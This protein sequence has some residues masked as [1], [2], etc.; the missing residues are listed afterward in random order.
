[1]SELKTICIMPQ[2]SGVGGPAAF[3]ERISA[4]L[5]KHGIEVS[6]DLHA[7][8]DAVLLISAWRQIG[9]LQRLKRSGV[10]VIQR[11]DGINW[12]H[13][14]IPFN[15]RYYLKAEYGNLLMRYTR[16]ALADRI[17]YQSEF[18]AQRWQQVY[19]AVRA[20]HTVIHNGIDLQAVSPQ[21]RVNNA[22]ERQRILVVEG[23]FGGG[24]D[25]GVKFVLDMAAGVE[26]RYGIPVEV[27]L[28]GRVTAA[29]Q[30]KW[31]DYTQVPVSWMGIVPREEIPV[32][33]RSAS[34][35]FSVDLNPAC[36]NTV[37]EA[38]AC[39]L[40]VV[41]YD[42]GALPEMVSG[43]A[44]RVVPYQADPWKLELPPT[45]GLID[46]A[47]EILQNQ[48]RFRAGARARAE[49]SFDLKDMVRKYLEVLQAV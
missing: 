45:E 8:C 41:A 23:S 49:E 43:D 30:D 24:Y 11:L 27:Q 46:A 32:L 39:G 18:V 19:G 37:I 6:A 42:T 20:P 16:R 21:G 29:V 44:G 9:Q 35:F 33:N 22:G 14:V 1:M 15:L 17:I 48:V 12:M 28:V 5:A 4:G 7:D 26:S 2:T 25:M 31:T 38:L 40:P 10:P 13:R 34:L 47:A 36:P 3:R